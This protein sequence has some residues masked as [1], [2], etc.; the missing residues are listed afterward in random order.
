MAD[1]KGRREQPAPPGAAGAPGTGARGIALPG[2]VPPRNALGAVPAGGS[3]LTAAPRGAMAG[4][5]AV[6]SGPSAEAARAG[7]SPAEASGAELPPG[8]TGRMRGRGAGIYGTIITAAVLAAAGKAEGIADVAIT[9]LVTL[10]V[11]WLAEQYSELLGDQLHL[12]HL[13][14]W[15]AVGSGLAATRSMVSA[16]FIPL[17]AV[18]LARLARAPMTLAVNLGLVAAVLTLIVYAWL[19]GRSAELRGWRLV[20][21]AALAA[22][23]GLVMIAL[24]DL[25][26]LQLH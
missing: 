19:A 4:A 24:K 17:A 5:A 23:L 8:R 26:I 10:V 21:V 16:S 3:S 7:G 12:G 25:V 15:R 20:A 11:Y 18:V 6:P 9:V 22:V 13:P 2:A 14:S 1:R